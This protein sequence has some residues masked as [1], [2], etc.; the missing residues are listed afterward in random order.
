MSNE[1]DAAP[2]R[3]SLAAARKA[4]R[5]GACCKRTGLSCKAPAMPSGRCRIHGGASTGPRT[6]EGLARSRAARLVH[7]KRDAAARA[8]A[9]QRGAAQARMAT[10][11]RLMVELEAELDAEV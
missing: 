4:P 3:S 5:C 2:S 9:A 8:Q 10:L 7:G 1:P 6:T 11:R